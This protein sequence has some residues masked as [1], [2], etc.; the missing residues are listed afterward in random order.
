MSKL[1]VKCY[2]IFRAEVTFKHEHERGKKE[3]ILNKFSG[4]QAQTLFFS[5]LVLLICSH[6]Y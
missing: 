3:A 6:M 5:E 2:D 1:E 4:F